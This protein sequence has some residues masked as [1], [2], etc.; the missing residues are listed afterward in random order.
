MKVVLISGSMPPP[1]G[2]RAMVARGSTALVERAAGDAGGGD[3]SDA[4]RVVFWAARGDEAV[5]D[6]AERYGR[7]TDRRA[8]FIVFVAEAGA[9]A[10]VG[11]SAT[12]RFEWPADEDRLRMAFETGA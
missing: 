2:L 11:L 9:A 3:E 7:A 4:D 10:P 8:D 5:R 6:L 1:E 12:E